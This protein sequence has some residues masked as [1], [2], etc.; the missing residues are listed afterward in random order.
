LVRSIFGDS[1]GKSMI[2]VAVVV[3]AS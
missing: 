3:K 1:I 2:H